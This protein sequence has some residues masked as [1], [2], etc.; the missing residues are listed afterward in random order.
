V[1]VADLGEIIAAARNNGGADDRKQKKPKG[2]NEI[3]SSPEVV[4]AMSLASSFCKMGLTI[5][6]AY[7]GELPWFFNFTLPG[8]TCHLAI[9]RSLRKSNLIP[10]AQCEGQSRE[11][12]SREGYRVDSGTPQEDLA[13][14][15]DTHDLPPNSP[16]ALGPRERVPALLFPVT[17]Q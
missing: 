10:D 12:P 16:I 14:H 6:Y 7:S 9:K 2:R 11:P 1:E 4:S 17:T 15:V 13:R 3:H 5:L 8:L